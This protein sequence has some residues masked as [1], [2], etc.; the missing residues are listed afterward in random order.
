MLKFCLCSGPEI[1]AL[2]IT[3]PTEPVD[4]V[5]ADAIIDSETQHYGDFCKSL[6]NKAK[7]Q[8]LRVKTEAAVGA[9]CLPDH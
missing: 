4:I 2:S 3:Q 5:E 7:G 6:G 1:I 9:S 8:N